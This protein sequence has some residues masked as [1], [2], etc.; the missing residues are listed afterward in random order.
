MQH[1][2]RAN[3]K[4]LYVG[5]EDEGGCNKQSNH[6][7]LYK[8]NA[9]RRLRKTFWLCADMHDC[10][11]PSVHRNDHDLFCKT[12]SLVNNNNNKIFNAA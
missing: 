8:I 6:V 11:W 9:F 3:S 2:S 7:G 5:L 1:P 10:V 12:N 4:S